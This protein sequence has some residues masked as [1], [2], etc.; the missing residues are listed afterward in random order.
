LLQEPERIRPE[1]KRYRSSIVLNT[2]G[3]AGSAALGV[4]LAF[5][6]LAVAGWAD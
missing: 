4:F 6:L 5:E 3:R 1:S 2:M